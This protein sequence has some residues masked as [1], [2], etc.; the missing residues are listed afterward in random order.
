MEDS[1]R[2][3]CFFFISQMQTEQSRVSTRGAELVFRYIP[4]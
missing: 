3:S 4:V 2:V 1:V